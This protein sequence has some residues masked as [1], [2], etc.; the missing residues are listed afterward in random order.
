MLLM[1]AVIICLIW[2]TYNVFTVERTKTGGLQKMEES[3]TTDVLPT[4]EGVLIDEVKL[5]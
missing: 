3:N 5:R 2:Y 4:G 1:Y